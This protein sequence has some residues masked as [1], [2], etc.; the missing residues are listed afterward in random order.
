MAGM[1]TWVLGAAALVAAVTI[2]WPAIRSSASW[3]VRWD[4][5]TKVILNELVTNQGESVKDQVGRAVDL[6]EQ[7]QRALEVHLIDHHKE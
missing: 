1:F 4:R 6:G 3:I 5:A 2:L 7:N